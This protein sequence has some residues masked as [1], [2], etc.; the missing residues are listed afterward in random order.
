LLE[1]IV[2]DADEAR[3]AAAAGADRLELVAAFER[4]GLTPSLATVAAVARA[5]TIP[6]HVMLRPHDRGFRY[7]AG[8]L[9]TDCALAGQL[10]DT[11]AAAIVYGALDAEGRVDLASVADIAASARI[12]LTF[13]RAFDEARDP[14]EAHAELATLPAVTRVLTSGQ[15][16]DAWTGRDVLRRL[17]ERGRPPAL[18]PGAGISARNVVALVR[19]TGARE[20]HVGNGARTD[21][22]I[23]PHKIQQLTELLARA[24]DRD[25]R[26]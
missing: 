24:I 18:L 9:A 11:G 21:G 7:G 19:A 17:I 3:R 6:V 23:D 13:H 14:D 15:A 4:G 2:T 20:V 5:V 10:R 16:P 8:E 12:P 22:R 26:I 1:V 25:E